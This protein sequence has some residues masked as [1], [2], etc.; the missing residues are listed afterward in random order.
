MRLAPLLVALGWLAGL[1]VLGGLVW[2]V[3]L[4]ALLASVSAVGWWL[5]P[6][7]GLESVP[8]LLHTAGWAACFPPRHLAGAFWPLALVRLAGSAINQVTPTATLGGEVV[9]VLLL[10]ATVPRA[11]ATATVVMD[12]TS[13]VLAQSVVLALGAWVLTQRLALPAAVHCGLW[14]TVGLLALGVGGFVVVQRY[15]V[16]STMLSWLSTDQRGWAGLARW[17]QQLL[18]LEAAL[19]ATYQ[20]HPGRFGVSVGLHGGA[21]AFNSLQTWL[22]LRLLLGAQAPSLVDAFLVTSAVAAVEQIGFFVPG[23][24]GTAE[25]VRVALLVSLGVAP[26]TGVALGLMARLEWGVWTGVGLLAGGWSM[27]PWWGGSR[28]QA[29]ASALT[30]D[31]PPPW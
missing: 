14:L 30:S 25:A 1:G 29:R 9:K 2:H 13:A 11:M 23:G 24:L 31:S 4:T 15:G 20:T 27:R 10:E 12:K 26:V 21:Y 19:A 16:C 28:G 17:R 5:G 22:A 6:W 3:G 7:V 18:P 8:V